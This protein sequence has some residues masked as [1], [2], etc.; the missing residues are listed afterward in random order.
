M[1]KKLYF[2]KAAVIVLVAAFTNICFYLP[3]V[4]A[5]NKTDFYRFDGSLKSSVEF[6]NHEEQR[7]YEYF[8]SGVLF[9]DYLR[10]KSGQGFRKVYREDGTLSREEIIKKY[11]VVEKKFFNSRGVLSQ[12]EVYAEDDPSSK[13]IKRFYPFG[14]LQSERYYRSGKLVDEGRIYFSDGKI[15]ENHFFKGGRTEHVLRFDENGSKVYDLKRD[16]LDWEIS[17]FRGERKN[18][19]L[20][21]YTRLG[22]AW[23]KTFSHGALIEEKVFYEGGELFSQRNYMNGKRHGLV[24]LYR[25]DGSLSH[26]FSYR[27][28]VREEARY[29][30]EEGELELHEFFQ[31]GKRIK[32]LEFVKKDLGESEKPVQQSPFL[33][34]S[35]FGAG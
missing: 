26:E 21:G 28:G 12:L 20:R 29:F 16:D 31:D 4:C 8:R 9:S 24:R 22:K 7:V 15:K 13:V 23:E 2:T 34:F 33:S 19:P 3:Q 6:L 30:A 18:G 10:S 1:F 25:R 11:R 5:E 17:R 14:A 27:N 35:Q 32:K